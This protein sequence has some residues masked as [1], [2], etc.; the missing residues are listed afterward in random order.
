MKEVCKKAPNTAPFGDAS[1]RAPEPRQRTSGPWWWDCA[2]PAGSQAVCVAWS[3]FRQNGVVASRESAGMV[4]NP[5]HAAQYPA[6]S[7]RGIT[8]AVGQ[9]SIGEIEEGK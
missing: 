6:E 8:Q 2:R 3:G 7:M 9:I 4:P 1:R 5:A